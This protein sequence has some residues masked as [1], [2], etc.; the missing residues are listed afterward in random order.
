M[1]AADF[2]QD[3]LYIEYM[4]RFDPQLWDLQ[5]SWEQFEPGMLRVW[6]REGEE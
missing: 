3:R 6:D 5:T 4:V 2:D 1:A